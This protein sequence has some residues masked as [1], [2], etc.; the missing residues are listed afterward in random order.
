MDIQDAQIIIL[1]A[2]LSAGWDVEDALKKS[3]E[4]AT[5][6]VNNDP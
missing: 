6:L 5:E 2:L 3:K 4:I 1:H